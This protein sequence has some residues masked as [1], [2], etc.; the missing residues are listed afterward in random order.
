M[1][2]RQRAVQAEDKEERRHA[3]LDAAEELLA[4]EVNRVANMA[5]VADRAGLAKGTVYLYFP[6]KD[7]L[8]VALH[9]RHAEA[10]F[11]ALI[12]RLEQPTTLTLDE[13][14]GTHDQPTDVPSAR[15]A[16]FRPDGNG[17]SARGRVGLQAAH[18][19]AVDARRCRS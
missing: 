12:A 17:N 5:E 2:I 15:H 7:E 10:F 13:M 19:R 11:K 6:S 14:R 16:V 1:V 9:E 8:L 3:I 4:E 18:D